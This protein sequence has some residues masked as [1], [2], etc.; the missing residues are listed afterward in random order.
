M[1]NND[2]RGKTITIA[3]TT[4]TKIKSTSTK[5]I[6]N[7]IDNNTCDV[8]SKTEYYDTD[9][10]LSK[11]GFTDNT[12]HNC[13]KKNSDLHGLLMQCAK[14]KK[15]YYCGMKVRLVVFVI[16]ACLFVIKVKFPFNT[17][18]PPWLKVVCA[19]VL[20]PN[21]LIQPNSICFLLFLR[22]NVNT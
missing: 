9:R 11:W 10:I 5:N 8:K 7:L 14:C 18:V 20:S 15:A 3:T 6:K 13:L 4:P 19:M 16:A 12:C 2:S 17:F 21:L 1:M 22:L